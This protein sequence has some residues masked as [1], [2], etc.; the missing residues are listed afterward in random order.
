MQS[1]KT[2]LETNNIP[3]ETRS[4]G[5]PNMRYKRVKKLYQQYNSECILTFVKHSIETEKQKDEHWMELSDKIKETSFECP[6]CYDTIKD[7]QVMNKCGHKLCISCFSQHI[8]ENN[9]CPMCRVEIC[10]K[11]KKIIKMPT[12]MRRQLIQKTIEETYEDRAGKTLVNYLLY[13]FDN[14]VKEVIQSQESL[15]SDSLSAETKNKIEEIKH[16]TK[17]EIVYSHNDVALEME[18]YY[19]SFI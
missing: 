11:P 16:K 1:F 9:N 5:M 8:R 3:F 6:I 10:Q 14:V 15:N 7:N 18:K 19:C 13:Q 12:E 17:A 4:D 2:Y